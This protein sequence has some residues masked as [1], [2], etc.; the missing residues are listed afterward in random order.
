MKGTARR[1]LKRLGLLRAAR[2][3]YR[4]FLGFCRDALWNMSG[5]KNSTTESDPVPAPSLC[6][7]SAASYDP[8]HF[9]T[10]G[11]VGAD[12][13]R[14]AVAAAG[15]SLSDFEKVLDFGS[16]C[17]RIMHHL[18][19]DL[20][21]ASVTACEI[22]PMAV[23]WLKNKPDISVMRIVQGE[24]LPCG[25]NSFDLIL[26]VAVFPLLNIDHQVLYMK[27]LRRVLSPEGIALVTF[28]GS[29]RKNELTPGELK[30]FQSGRPVVREPD[31]SGSLYC[32]AYLPEEFVR[33]VLVKDFRV[34]LFESGGSADTKQDMWL[35]QK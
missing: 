8:V 14:K 11:R 19:K 21:E 20:Q 6:F 22:D 35:L 7:R 15:R 1:I 30:R 9:I 13:V 27:E 23:D 16:G 24:G 34:L 4:C 5:G 18:L 17:C 26:A 3:I 2:F 12:S 33:T 31:F 25:S 32:L 28:K 10:S 29:S